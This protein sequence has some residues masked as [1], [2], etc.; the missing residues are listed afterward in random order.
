MKT[1]QLFSVSV[2]SLLLFA[3]CHTSRPFPLLPGEKVI[4]HTPARANEYRVWS[5]NDPQPTNRVVEITRPC[6]LTTE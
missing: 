5:G 3:G 2:F 6:S 4:F 1:F